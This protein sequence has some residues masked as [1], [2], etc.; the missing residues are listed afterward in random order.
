MRWDRRT[1]AR[2]AGAVALAA[3]LV[4][5]APAARASDE[6]MRINEV[7]LSAGGNPHAQ[8]I[9]LLD[10]GE[11]FEAPAYTLAVHAGDGSLAGAQVFSG[12]G[13]GFANDF[14]PHVLA[15]DAANLPDRGG[16]LSFELP[17]GGGQVC[18]YRGAEAVASQAIHCQGYGGVSS[19]VVAGMDV[20]AVPA[21]GQSLQRCPSGGSRVGVP[22]PGAVTPAALC[23]G[24]PPPHPGPTADPPGGGPSAAPSP[25]PAAPASDRRP[26]VVRLGGGLRQDVDRLVVTV[27]V[28][29]RATTTTTAALT[30][31]RRSAAPRSLAFR[32]A[33]TRA[34][35]GQTQRVRVKMGPLRLRRVKAALR[36][37]DRLRARVSVVARDGAGNRTRATRVITLRDR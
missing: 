16:R 9:E 6:L 34:F 5:A 8:F 21:D 14:R 15:T 27:R 30:L 28:D 35:A 13:Y 36:R 33:R 37:G 32:T 23:V 26:P 3:S 7:G 1:V 10:P 22:T 17:L 11:A 4:A 24:D 25:P 19:P 18:F 20:G 2:T 31:T 29:E 12:G